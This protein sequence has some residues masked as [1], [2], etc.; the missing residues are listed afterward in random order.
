MA[1]ERAFIHYARCHKTTREPCD[2]V[3]YISQQD[4]RI[5]PYISEVQWQF[6]D[7]NIPLLQLNV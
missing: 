7:N 4:K 2:G 1:V 3:K 6:T 5:E